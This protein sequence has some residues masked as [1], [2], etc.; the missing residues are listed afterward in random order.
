MFWF[1]HGGAESCY[2]KAEADRVRV[3]RDG[4]RR[5]QGRLAS[6]LSRSCRDAEAE[7]AARDDERGLEAGGAEEARAAQ[8]VAPVTAFRG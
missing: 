6:R 1:T 8:R 7:L 2:G 5:R 3:H 4:R